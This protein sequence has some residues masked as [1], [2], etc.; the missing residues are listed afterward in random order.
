MR[1]K[2]EDKSGTNRY[3]Q[4]NFA[5]NRPLTHFIV[6]SQPLSNAFWFV[7]V[8]L[9]KWFPC[10]IVETLDLWWSIRI[11]VYSSGC[12]MYPADGKTRRRLLLANALQ[13]PAVASVSEINLPICDTFH[14]DF[15]RNFQIHNHV[16]SNYLFK[17]LGLRERSGK[18]IQ[19]QGLSSI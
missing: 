19:E 6:S 7:I 8:S 3:F 17:G 10:L 9:H 14:Y 4:L 15:G 11:G 5:V 18:S 16:N 13:K 1:R 2:S 12:R